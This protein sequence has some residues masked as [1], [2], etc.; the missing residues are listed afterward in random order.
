MRDRP[1]HEPERRRW[2]DADMAKLR[3]QGN[4]AN[5]GGFRQPRRLGNRAD[6]AVP[7]D[8]RRKDYLTFMPNAAAGNGGRSLKH[9]DCPIF[10]TCS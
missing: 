6:I 4:D 9:Q 2:P 8:N 1:Y 7:R 10:R 5:D 3:Q